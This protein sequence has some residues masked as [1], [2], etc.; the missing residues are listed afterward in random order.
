MIV[1]HFN[2]RGL[3][4]SVGIFLRCG[5]ICLWVQAARKNYLLAVPACLYAINNYLKFIMQVH[6]S[7]C[8][9]YLELGK[10]VGMSYEM[11]L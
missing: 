10:A 8:I 1:Q 5:I 2:V 9:K 3:T 7:S 4:V 11:N 6:L